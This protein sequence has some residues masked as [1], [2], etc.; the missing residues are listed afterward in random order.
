MLFC[1]SYHSNLT[2][3]MY[4]RLVLLIFATAFC[5]CNAGV[6]A[7]A[8]YHGQYQRWALLRLIVDIFNRKIFGVGRKTVK[9]FF[10]HVFFWR[11][12]CIFGPVL[13]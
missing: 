5:Y 9:K 10:L 11:F 13:V 7:V 8:I 1:G 3:M 2:V 4:G 6:T 12:L